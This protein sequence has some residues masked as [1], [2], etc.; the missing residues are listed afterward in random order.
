MMLYQFACNRHKPIVSFEVRQPIHDKH[1]AD[2]PKCRQPARRVYY[3]VTHYWPDVLWNKDGSK[4]SPDELPPV[5]KG[6]GRLYHGF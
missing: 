6:P 2:C 5:G 3:P 1:K 4:Q